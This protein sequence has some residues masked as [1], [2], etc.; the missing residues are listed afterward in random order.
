MTPERIEQ[1]RKAFEAWYIKYLPPDS[2]I[3]YFSRD[4]TGYKTYRT[5]TLWEGWLARA[6]QS[7]WISVEDRLPEHHSLIL[8]AWR[9]LKGGSCR[10]DAF[11]Y[12][13]TSQEYSSLNSGNKLNNNVAGVTHWQPLPAP[14]TTN[15][16]A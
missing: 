2:P 8:A 4:D 10:V 1:E 14:P 15:P 3:L 12:D 16:A 9:P 6:A 13:A 7:E 11:I 5:R